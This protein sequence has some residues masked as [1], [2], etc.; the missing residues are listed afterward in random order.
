SMSGNKT[1]HNHSKLRSQC[2]IV[3]L[4]RVTRAVMISA[5]P[6]AGKFS[7]L[8]RPGGHSEGILPDP[9]PNSAVKAFCVHGT[10]AQAAGESDAARSAK[11]RK[12]EI[13]RHHKQQAPPER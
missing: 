9:I 4:R 7:A 2:R 1:R 10:A 13:T 12:T 11:D 3:L 5:H 8:R 6:R